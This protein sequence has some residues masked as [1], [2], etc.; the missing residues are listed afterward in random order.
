MAA[1]MEECGAVEVVIGALWAHPTHAL[2][3]AS[4]LPACV[5]SSS[6]HAPAACV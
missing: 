3:Q 2:L 5:R 6:N 1:A 4:T